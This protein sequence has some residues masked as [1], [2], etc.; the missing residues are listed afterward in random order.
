MRFLLTLL[1]LSILA[2]CGQSPS[3]SS[4]GQSQPVSATAATFQ[5]S[6]KASVTGLKDTSSWCNGAFTEAVLINAD[7][8]NS[9]R[10]YFQLGGGAYNVAVQLGNATSSFFLQKT[11]DQ[12]IEVF[13]SDNFPLCSSN[14][15][16]FSLAG[17][18]ARFRYDNSRGIHY[19]VESQNSAEGLFVI[20][21]FPAEMTY[22]L[23]VYHCVGCR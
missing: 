9:K 5:F 7:T 4:T 21:E 2:G 13:T 8:A 10:R 11:G 6:K 14:R 22:G 18:G 3:T 17:E 20:L 16:N 12:S 1:F 23:T 15:A 19:T